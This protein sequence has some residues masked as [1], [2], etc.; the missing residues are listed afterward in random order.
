M[1]PKVEEVLDLG[2]IVRPGTPIERKL[3]RHGSDEVPVYVKREDLCCPYPGPQFSKIRGVAAHIAKRPEGVI[4]ALDTYHS[5]AGWA[6]AYVCAALGK[7]SVVYWPRFKDDPPAGLPRQPQREA[8]ASGAATVALAAGRSAILY[9]RARQHLKEAVGADGYMM[10]NALKLPETVHE[11]AMEVDRSRN[12]LPEGME[13]GTL[14]ISVSS[15]TIAAG[16]LA[17]FHDAGLWPD[18]VLH[19]G[20]SRPEGAVRKYLAEMSKVD[21]G[22]FHSVQVVDEGYGYRDDAGHVETLDFPCNPYYDLKT[23]KWLARNTHL[24]RQPILFWNIGA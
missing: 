17:G 21:L 23:W 8:K 3:I 10:P 16:V 20:Y 12:L 2:R 19:L 9:H 11:T 13:E 6:V 5:K 22:D 15:G 1:S 7:R 18:V 14:V 24:M 4:G